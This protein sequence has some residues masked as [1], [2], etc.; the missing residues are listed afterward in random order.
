MQRQRQLLATTRLR[1]LRPLVTLPTHHA[2]TRPRSH[3][4]PQ[5]IRLADIDG[6]GPTDTSTWAATHGLVLQPQGNRL[7][8]ARPIP[9]PVATENRV[10]CRVARPG[11]RNGLP[12]VEPHLPADA[13]SPV[14]Y[15]ELMAEG[16]PPADRGAQPWWPI[17]RSVHPVHPLLPR[18][19]EPRRLVG[20]TAAHSRCT[21]S[22][23]V[24]AHDLARQLLQQ[25]HQL[26]PRG[27]FDGAE[28]SS[29]GWARGAGGR[30]RS[31]TRCLTSPRQDH[32]LVHTG[33]TLD[34]QRILGSSSP[35]ASATFCQA[36]ARSG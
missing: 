23:R 16:K 34:R 28:R 22:A 18:R 29:V 14:R 8:H 36:A 7:S 5:R 13:A 17:P 11:Q 10:P 2:S 3:F 27:Y 32:H 19:S 1:P 4:D 12:G 31:A 9:L 33:A 24:T 6:S 15:V 20:D 21:A 25:P 30:G 35:S 26:P